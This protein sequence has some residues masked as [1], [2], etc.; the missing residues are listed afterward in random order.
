MSLGPVGPDTSED[1]ITVEVAGIPAL[2][3]SKGWKIGERFEQ[4]GDAFQD[5]AKDVLDVVRLCVR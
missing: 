2:V 4:G 1:S 3:V 5:V